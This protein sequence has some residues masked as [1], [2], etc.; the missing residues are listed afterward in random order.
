MKKKSS[1]AKQTAKKKRG[2]TKKT[3]AKKK[4]T[5]K[6]TAKKKKR[7]LKKELNAYREKLLDLKD[8]I[9][10][11]I[12][13]ISDESLR[14]SQQEASGDISAYSLHL[15]DRA[16]DSYERDF[17]LGLIS[18][19]RRTVME[20]DEALKRIDDNQYGFCQMCKKPIAKRRLDAIPYARY[21]T[22]CQQ[23][24]EKEQGR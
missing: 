1:Q 5:K 16:S 10:K 8:D 13:E 22:K 20:I 3:T 15:A 6:K 23:K 18:S 7:F 4:T 19:E 17:N 14:K 24:I 21:G 11:Q 9:M 12:Q 2:T